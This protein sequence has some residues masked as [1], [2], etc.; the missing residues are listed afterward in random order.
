MARPS[1]PIWRDVAGGQ[2]RRAGCRAPGSSWPARVRSASMSPASMTPSTGRF[3]AVSKRLDRLLGAGAELAVD[4]DLEAGARE[5]VLEDPDVVAAHPALDRDAVAEAV[6]RAVVV[7]VVGEA[8]VGVGARRRAARACRA[9]TVRVPTVP[10]GVEARGALEALDGAQRPGAEVAV[11]L[12]LEAGLAERL[13]ELAH[14]GARGA[15]RAAC[16]RRGATPWPSGSRARSARRRRVTPKAS[17]A[18]TEEQRTADRTAARQQ[19]P[20]F[21]RAPTGLAVGLARKRPRYVA[22]RRR[23]APC[24]RGGYWVPRSPPWHGRDSAGQNDRGNLAD[25]S[26]DVVAFLESDFDGASARSC[27]V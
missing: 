11:D 27:R 19:R 5:E 12:D 14:V 26:A 25:R 2:L 17:T 16:G 7:G 22:L 6:V 8:A 9:A 23:F 10:L 20:L 3:C 21:F 13:L 18:T 1:G 4:A 24:H 15:R